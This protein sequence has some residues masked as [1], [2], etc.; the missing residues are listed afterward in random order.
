GEER[1]PRLEERISGEQLRIPLFKSGE[2]LLFFFGKL[3]EDRAPARVLR[4]RRGAIVEV[5]PA[6]FGR[7][8]DAERVAGKHQLRCRAID[9]RDTGRTRGTSAAFFAGA[10]DLYNGLSRFEIAGRGDLFHQRLDIGAEELRRAMT[11]L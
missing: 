11:L 6:A 3:L 7:N 1:R 2:M 9:V 4:E 8:R 5:E 10:D